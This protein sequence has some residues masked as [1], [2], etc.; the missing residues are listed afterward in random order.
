MVKA[1]ICAYY[2]ERKIIKYASKCFKKTF[3]KY[4][5]NATRIHKIYQEN[6]E[7]QLKNY[8]PNFLQLFK[9]LLFTS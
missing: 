5:L 2:S 8:I 7:S 1:F 9:R 4:S 6:R 3:L